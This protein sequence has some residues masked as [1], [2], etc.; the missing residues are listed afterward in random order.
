[1]LPMLARRI[2]YAR[3]NVASPEFARA[4]SCEQRSLPQLFA[5]ERTR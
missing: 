5:T 2:A 1:M 4:A 3:L